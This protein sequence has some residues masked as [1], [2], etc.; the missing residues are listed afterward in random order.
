MRKVLAVAVLCLCAALSLA[1]TP[2]TPINVSQYAV[3][4]SLLQ[5]SPYGQNSAMDTTFSTVFSTNA[6]LQ[7]DFIL[8]PGASYSGYF[9][10]GSYNLSVL[11]P[12]LA[13]TSFSCGKFMPFVTAEAGLGR[14]APVNG[15]TVQ[16]FAGLVELGAGYDPTGS[17]KYGLAF[18]GGYGDFGPP[19]AGLS[20]KGWV[21]YSGIT[22]GGGSNALATAAK[23]ERMRRATVKKQAKLDAKAKKAAKG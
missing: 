3:N 16:G 11:C 20:N 22:F 6:T 13:S 2:V 8:M 12:A 14:I 23:V 1:Q 7:A 17:G 9:G 10:G 19:V 5:G 4:L 18:K 15:T 21:F